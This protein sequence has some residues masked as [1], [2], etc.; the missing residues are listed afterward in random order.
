MINEDELICDMAQYYHIYNYRNMDLSLIA[1]LS[2]GLPEDSRSMRII[3]GQKISR[4]EL[5]LACLY[6]DF[7]TYLW[8]MTKDAKHGR[9]KPESIAK[10][11]LGM[12]EKKETEKTRSFAT[13]QEFERAKAKI[14]GRI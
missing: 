9:N 11:W 6:D 13:P 2:A 10:K 4:T 1:T 5:M 8:S 14:L 12:D 3:S 7:N